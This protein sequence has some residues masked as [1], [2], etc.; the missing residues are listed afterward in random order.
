M[1]NLAD[2]LFYDKNK[3]AA[4]SSGDAIS[5][6]AWNIAKPLYQSTVT[7]SQNTLNDVMANPAYAGPRVAGLNGIQ[8]GSANQLAGFA[9][10]TANLGSMASFGTGLQNL[11]PSGQ[12]GQNA[13]A[14]FSQSGVD[15]TQQILFNANQY[16][17]NPYVN[18]I[19]DAASRDVTRNLYENQLP[20]VGLR[21]SGTGNTNSTRAGVESA[22]LQR[23]AADRLTDLASNIRGQFFNTGLS[24]A[25]DQY[26]QNL[27]NMLQANTQLYNAGQLGLTG[28]NSAQTFAQNAFNQGQGAGA[29][30]QTQDQNELDAN[31]AYFDESLANRLAA[32]QASGSIAGLQ[33]GFDGGASSST[34]TEQKRGSGLSILGS[35]MKMFV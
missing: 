10:R 15:P 13:A 35:T 16:A 9:D 18:G 5:K 32:L 29:L 25:Q 2:T 28:L 4:T 27:A 14:L 7:G 30:Y 17:N 8:T 20:G 31:K 19:I 23:G 12:Y 34:S 11:M 24:Q 1:G 26:N 21:A 6:D 33:S 3:K 22:I